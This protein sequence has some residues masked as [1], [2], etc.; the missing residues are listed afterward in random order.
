[1][2]NA[3]DRPFG[4]SAAGLP[5]VSEGIT[6]FFQPLTFGV[7][8]QT[9]VDGYTNDAVVSVSTKGMWSPMSPQEVAIK[10]EGERAWIWDSVFCLPDIVLYP[11]DRIVYQGVNYKVMS[12]RDW[13]A[14]GYLEYSVVNEFSTRP[15]GA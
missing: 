11:G 8:T 10:P 9:V 3:K 6:S 1:M 7:I 13:A 14:Y 4:Q 5:D 15:V 12:K 2:L